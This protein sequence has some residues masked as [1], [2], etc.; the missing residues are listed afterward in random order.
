[1]EKIKASF[2]NGVLKVTMP[3]RSRSIEN[4]RKIK[5]ETA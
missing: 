2:K 4:I 3:R 5:I 1:M